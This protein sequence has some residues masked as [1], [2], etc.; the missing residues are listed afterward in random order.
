MAVVTVARAA[1]CR[2]GPGASH[3][4]FLGVSS[5]REERPQRMFHFCFFFKP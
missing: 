1:I 3:L 4:L 5:P 2:A